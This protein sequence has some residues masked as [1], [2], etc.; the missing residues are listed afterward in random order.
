MG[1]YSIQISIIESQIY[2]ASVLPK[3]AGAHNGRLAEPDGQLSV[4]VPTDNQ[5]DLRERSGEPL[6]FGATHIRQENNAIGPI[7]HARQ[8][9]LE[10]RHRIRNID[11]FHVLRVA[12]A[13]QFFARE[14]N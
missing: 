8:N 1:F 10:R 14:S 12:S 4:F 6:F 5:P 11:I 9:A 13:L 2:T 3:L 7:P